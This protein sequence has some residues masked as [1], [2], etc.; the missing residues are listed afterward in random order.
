MKRHA[1]FTLVELMITITIMVILV[2]LSVVALRSTQANARDAEREADATSIARAIEQTYN[3]TNPRATSTEIS[4]GSYPGTNEILHAMGFSRVGYTPAQITGGYLLDLFSGLSDDSLRTP[5]SS[6]LSLDL[7]C[8]FACSPAETA[9]VV[10]SQTTI[11][12][13]IYEPIDKNG[14]ICY[15]GNCVRFNLY[16]RTEV[17]N[18]VHKITSKNQ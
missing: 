1:G 3:T 8:V 6:T 15:T 9:S 18:V 2:S 5:G 7:M 13:Y 16:Y 11:A 14:A 4:K 12:K 17:D 10:N